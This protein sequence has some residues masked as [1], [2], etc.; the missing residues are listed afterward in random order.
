V[1]L[2]QTLNFE[3]PEQILYAAEGLRLLYREA[4]FWESL[5]P[6]QPPGVFNPALPEALRGYDN[7]LSRR[8]PVVRML[9][10]TVRA[11]TEAGHVALVVA[12]PIP[13]EELERRPWYDSARMQRRIDLLRAVTEDAGG[14]FADLHR[15][16]TQ[17]EFSDYGG[18]FLA[19]G[20]LHVS[21]AIWPILRP[22]L[23][24]AVIGRSMGRRAHD[25]TP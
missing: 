9:E 1:L 10:A 8:Q 13:Y 14:I 15:L 4:P 7:E 23:R 16:L 17:A 24:H 21:N 3:T 5:G 2:A 20:A 6:P 22:A 18:H 19:S 25:P 12:S 11:V